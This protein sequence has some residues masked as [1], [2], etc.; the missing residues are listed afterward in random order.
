MGLSPSSLGCSLW[1]I[2]FSTCLSGHVGDSLWVTLIVSLMDSAIS[3]GTHLWE[4]LKGS[5]GHFYEELTER[6]SFPK[7]GVDQKKR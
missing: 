7:V 5:Q 1:S 4:G 6:N 2:L 3:L